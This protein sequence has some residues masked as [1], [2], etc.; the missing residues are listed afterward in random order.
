MRNLKVFC[1]EKTKPNKAKQSQFQAP[2]PTPKQVVAGKDEKKI[3]LEGFGPPTFG[4]VDRRSIQ[5]SYR[6]KYLF[7]KDI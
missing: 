4:S 5:L 2:T 1:G 6:R 3:R 7:I